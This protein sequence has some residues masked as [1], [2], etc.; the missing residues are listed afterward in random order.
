VIRRVIRQEPFRIN[1]LLTIVAAKLPLEELIQT[2]EKVI[3]TVTAS[4]ESALE[5]ENALHSLQNILPQLRGRVAEH[6]QW[7]EVENDFWEA[8]DCIERRTPDSIEEFGE[9]W[10]DTKSRVES[11]A[12]TEPETDWAKATKR[13]AVQIDKDVADHVDSAVEKFEYFR[14]TALFHFYQ[15]DKALKAQCAEILKFRAPLRSLLSKVG[16]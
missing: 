11:L 13:Q 3:N 1:A 6:K 8:E 16:S 14:K 12:R 15:V 7:Q 2:I 4:G 10:P 9:L 5:L